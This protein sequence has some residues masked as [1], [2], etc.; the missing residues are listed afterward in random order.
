[1]QATR[2]ALFCEQTFP[3]IAGHQALQSGNVVDQV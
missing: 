1:M 3:R 2:F